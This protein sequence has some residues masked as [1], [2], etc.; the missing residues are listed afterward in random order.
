MNSIE[1][2]IK[3][4]GF[5][6][7]QL[8]GAKS[9][10]QIPSSS[11]NEKSPSNRALRNSFLAGVTTAAGIAAVILIGT[12]GARLQRNEEWKMLFS[13]IV[14]SECIYGTCSYFGVPKEDKKAVKLGVL[15]GSFISYIA[16]SPSLSMKAAITASAVSGALTGISTLTSREKC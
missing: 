16:S 1:R 14:A 4:N 11:L 5:D 6:N 12:T 13:G 7:D 15:L 10:K 9:W 2:S 3:S 8:Q